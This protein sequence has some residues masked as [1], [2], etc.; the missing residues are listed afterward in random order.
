M[1]MVILQ[2]AI[3]VEL[4]KGICLVQWAETLRRRLVDVFGLMT[5]ML[6]FEVDFLSLSEVG[7]SCQLI[8]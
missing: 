7:H 3:Y 8:V 1:K 2:F 5:N 4:P 6:R